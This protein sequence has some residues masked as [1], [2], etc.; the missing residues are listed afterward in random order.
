MLHHRF[1]LLV[2][3]N[4]RKNSYYIHLKQTITQISFAHIHSTL[5]KWKFIRLKN[6]LETILAQQW[7]RY[8][9][10]L[11]FWHMQY[12][13]L[14]KKPACSN[15]EHNLSNSFNLRGLGIS[16]ENFSSIT[17]RII[18]SLFCARAG[19]W[20]VPDGLMKRCVACFRK[21]CVSAFILRKSC[22][23]PLQLP[24]PRFGAWV[25]VIC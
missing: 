18:S 9:V 4:S 3:I 5:K 2:I 8:K 15:F 14:S 19:P 12:I 6:Q 13:F 23:S 24:F 1:L 17:H 7:A 11:N 22:V 25:P 21:I 10:L 16:H 20:T